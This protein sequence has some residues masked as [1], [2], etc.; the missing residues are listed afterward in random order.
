VADVAVVG[1]PDPDWGERVVAV[2]VLR[3]PLT[4]EQ[5]R[6]RVA[7]A[8]PRSHAPREL[9]VVDALPLLPSGKIDRM[10]LRG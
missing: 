3:A 4:L 5:A 8:L 9:R 10:G 7:A 2:V 1:V 6:D